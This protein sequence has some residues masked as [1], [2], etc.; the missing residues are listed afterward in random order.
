MV[1]CTASIYVCNITSPPFTDSR[2]SKVTLQLYWFY[3][4]VPNSHKKIIQPFNPQLS[5]L[6]RS[7]HSYLKNSD[8][9]NS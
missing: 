1:S 8:T 9:S 5:V 7:Y 4:S 6:E 2:G 3:K